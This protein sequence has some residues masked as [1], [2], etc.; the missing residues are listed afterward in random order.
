[1]TIQIGVNSNNDIFIDTNGDL[2]MVRDIN[3]CKEAAQQAAQVQL[4]EMQ[5]HVNRGVP[6]FE[7]IW[8]GHPSLAQFRA[9]VRRELVL[10]TDVSRV[11]S[12]NARINGEVV[13]YDAVI[14]STF[15]TGAVN[16]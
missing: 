14:E 4:G 13:T 5:Y 6:D 10:V 8:N 3:A 16:G 7:V 11:R 12:L 2:V 1:M 15:G 9:A